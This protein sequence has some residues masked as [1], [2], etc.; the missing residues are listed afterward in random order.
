L[1]RDRQS[2]PLFF[3]L[4]LFWSFIMSHQFESG[5]FVGRGAWHGLGTVLDHPPTTARAIALLIFY[6]LN[7]L[8]FLAPSRR[9]VSIQTETAIVRVID[10]TDGIPDITANLIS[11][12]P[13]HCHLPPDIF[14]DLVFKALNDLI[15]D[16]ALDPHKYI[17]PRHE[18]AIDS[19]AHQYLNS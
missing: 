2:F 4:S 6:L 13:E 17:K 14:E 1:I 12:Q 8:T 5:F 16:F 10:L 7:Y 19:I 18:T 9:L 11:D 3:F 15:D